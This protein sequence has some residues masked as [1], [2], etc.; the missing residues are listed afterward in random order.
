MGVAVQHQRI[1]LGT[2]R[3]IVLFE[4]SPEIAAQYPPLGQTD[5]CFLPRVSYFTG[6]IAIHEMAWGGDDLWF[7]N[8]RFSCLCTLDSHC[9]FV[10]RWRPRF[11]SS[12]VAEDRCHLNGL[13]IDEVRPRYATA[14]GISDTAEGWR[15]CKATNGIVMDINNNE[16]VARDLSMP[17]SPRIHQGKLWLCDSGRGRIVIVD[18]LTG[19]YETVAQLPGY[20]RGLAFCKPFLFVGLSRIRESSLFGGLELNNQSSDLKCGIWVLDVLSGSV[21]ATVEFQQ[22]IEEIFDV[23]VLMG[24]RFPALVGLQKDTAD[25]LFVLP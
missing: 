19:R 2:R 25:N 5:A 10:P 14:L 21:V 12:L 8:T 6:D 22:D 3:E 7:V 4:N 23:Q 11:V 18:Q 1:A 15:D 17:H 16:I 9:S 20:T 24:T 13:A